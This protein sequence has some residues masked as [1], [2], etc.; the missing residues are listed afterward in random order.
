MADQNKKAENIHAGHRK[1]MLESYAISG[2]EP[3]HEHEIL[4]MLLFFCIRRKD[5]NEIAHNLLKEF[6]SLV[7]V[8]TADREQLMLIDNIGEV[9]AT[10]LNLIGEAFKFCQRPNPNDTVTLETYQERRN[11]FLHQLQYESAKEIFMVACLDDAM[12]VKKCSRL[13][14]GSCDKVE[15]DPRILAQYVLASS[16]SNVI[17]AH[18]HPVGEAI[19]SLEDIL[20]TKDIKNT[21]Q[22]LG[23]DLVDHIVVGNGMAYS[24]AEQNCI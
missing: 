11:Y 13:R 7:G 8:V 4:E 15:L 22:S 24:M 20:S 14:K 19:P 16:C 10:Y 1:R 21:M 12:R 6:K 9:S 17:I 23:V 5:T 3:F 2:A 18:N